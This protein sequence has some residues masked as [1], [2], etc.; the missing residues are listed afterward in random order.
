MVPDRCVVV[1]ELLADRDV[2]RG[3]NPDASVDDLEPAVGPA[4]V[5]DEAR[6]VAANGRIA[7]PPAI[8]P[9]HP[10]AA[11]R[12]IARLALPACRIANQFAVIVDDASVLVD[13]LEREDAEPV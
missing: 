11:F 1:G 4:R 2:P 12:Q 5:V 3:A 9:K 10:D 7:T 8:D 13:R 6:D